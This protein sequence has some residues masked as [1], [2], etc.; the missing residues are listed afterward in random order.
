MRP[1]GGYFEL[2]LPA[3][4]EFHTGPVLRFNTARNALKYFVQKQGIG[5]IFLPAYICNSVVQVLKSAGVKIQEYS[6]A[7]DFMPDL[8]TDI[9][10]QAY[11]LYVNYF[12]LHTQNVLAVTEQYPNTIIDQSQA[13]YAPPQGAASIYSPRKF[14]GVPDGGYL[15]ADIAADQIPPDTSVG[16]VESLL[17]R[18]DDNLTRG[19]KQFQTTEALLAERPV[20]GMSNLTQRLLKSIDYQTIKAVRRTNFQFLADHLAPYNT[21]SVSLESEEVPMVYPFLPANGDYHRKLW[22]E[23]VFAPYL[24][25]DVRRKSGRDTL[26]GELS[27]RLLPLPIDQRYSIND[28]HRIISVVKR[29]LAQTDYRV[30]AK[31]EI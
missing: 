12:G 14:F 4:T 31:V 25:Q 10:D 1:I 11:L 6:L 23:M 27:H 15:Y 24:W 18:L 7:K 16:Y 26:A 8:P 13:F 3:G 30:P 29:I 2:E 28:M 19:F 17:Q 20:M 5:Q 9:P 21:L 22:E